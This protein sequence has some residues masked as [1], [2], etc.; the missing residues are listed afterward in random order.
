MFTRSVR[1]ACSF[2]AC[3]GELVKFQACLIFLQSLPTLVTDPKFIHLAT[4]LSV[5]FLACITSRPVL[6]TSRLVLQEAGV[7]HQIIPF[8][9]LYPGIFWEGP[10]STLG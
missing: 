9:I 6:I 2:P 3:R 8:F 5:N 1:V 4:G 7:S 10:E